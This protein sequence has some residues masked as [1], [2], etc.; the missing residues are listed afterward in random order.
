MLS[1]SGHLSPQVLGADIRAPP[2]PPAHLVQ[3][4]KTHSPYPWL[5]P[6]NMLST[7]PQGGSQAM[8]TA[9]EGAAFEGC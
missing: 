4:R 7:H 1:Q 2:I 5:G 9:S 3:I 6:Q 8:L